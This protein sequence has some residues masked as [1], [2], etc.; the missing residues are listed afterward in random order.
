MYVSSVEDIYTFREVRRKC[1]LRIQ[2]I[3]KVCLFSSPSW[4]DF[5]LSTNHGRG[6]GLSLSP[7]T[8]FQEEGMY[9]PESPSL[10]FDP[11]L[12]EK[13]GLMTTINE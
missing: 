5:L 6:V 2:R 1:M 13:V 4:I 9:S 7:T 11:P 3:R 10:F 12:E 8:V